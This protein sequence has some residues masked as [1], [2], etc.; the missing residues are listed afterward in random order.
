MFLKGLFAAQ[1][2]TG[3]RETELTLDFALL[4]ILDTK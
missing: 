2:P 3:K 1:E 4:Y